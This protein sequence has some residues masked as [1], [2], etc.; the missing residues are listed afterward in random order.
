MFGLMI[1][2]DLPIY[3][4]IDIAKH[5]VFSSLIEVGAVTE[6]SSV[7]Q[8][9]SGNRCHVGPIFRSVGPVPQLKMGEAALTSPIDLML[10]FR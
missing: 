8:S 1:V 5:F 7:M 10:R 9:I 6:L 4:M 3:N 2:Y